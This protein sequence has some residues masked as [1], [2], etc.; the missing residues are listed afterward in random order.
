[1][2]PLISQLVEQLAC[3]QKVPGSIPGLVII[4]FYHCCGTQKATS[5]RP[6]ALVACS[7]EC[8]LLGAI[9]NATI[10]FLETAFSARW[11]HHMRLLEIF[12]KYS[13][14]YLVAVVDEIDKYIW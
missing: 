11:D 9:N 5:E 3:I 4:Q 10:E 8:A 1:I 2:I 13:P 6:L 12:Q 14:T 7:I